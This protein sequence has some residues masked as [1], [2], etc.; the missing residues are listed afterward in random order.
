MKDLETEWDHD[1]L[2]VYDYRR[3][4]FGSAYFARVHGKN[5]SFVTEHKGLVT[6]EFN[7]DCI[8]NYRGFLLGYTLVGKCRSADSINI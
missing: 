8:I 3:G 4:Y 1:K 2:S 5:I 6:L 7:S